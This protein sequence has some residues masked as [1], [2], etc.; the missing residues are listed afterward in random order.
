[1]DDQSAII[2]MENM[3]ETKEFSTRSNIRGLLN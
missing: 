1:M 2:N 3:N